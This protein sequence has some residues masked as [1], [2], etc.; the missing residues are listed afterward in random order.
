MAWNERPRILHV[1]LPLEGGFEQVAELR[2]HR[3]CDGGE[4]DETRLFQR[5]GNPGD[6]ET[7]DDRPDEAADGAA[8]GLGRRNRRRQLRP[9]KRPPAEIGEDVGRPD[10]REEEQRRCEALDVAVAQEGD[11]KGG[12]R[13]IGEADRCRHAGAADKAVHQRQ[14]NAG[15]GQRDECRGIG[16]E[17][18]KAEEYD[19]QSGGGHVV[20]A[21]GVAAR[22]RRPFVEHG[23]GDAGREKAE[24]HAAEPGQKQRH[25]CQR[26]GRE[27]TRAKSFHAPIP[28]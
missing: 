10:G 17:D 15:H 19:Q 7:A 27:H 18:E 23:R 28:R 14:R 13:G 6:C 11:R 2:E 1:V 12:Q 9:A 5:P 8:P 21:G 20:A 4:D 26:Q 16:A 22:N 25:R 24:P 3:Q